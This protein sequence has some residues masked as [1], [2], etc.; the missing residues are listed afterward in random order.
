MYGN[1]CVNCGHE[2]ERH[3]P[4]LVNEPVLPE[5]QWFETI[6]PGYRMDLPKCMETK[7]NSRYKKFF[8]ERKLYWRT[9]TRTPT[10]FGYGDMSPCPGQES[11][12]YDRHI[13]SLR[14]S[15]PST[16]VLVAD[17]QRGHY[18]VCESE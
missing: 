14:Y 6:Q 17:P 1:L 9:H 8:S 7:C 13:D 2:E 10:R 12:Q 18:I 11:E 4:N 16:I 5:P 3:Q 15:Q